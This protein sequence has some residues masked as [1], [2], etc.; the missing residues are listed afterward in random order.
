ME[1]YTIYCPDDETS[2]SLEEFEKNLLQVGE[3]ISWYK[4]QQIFRTESW[5]G[6]KRED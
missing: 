4:Y 3:N 1:T 5:R 2:E 6:N